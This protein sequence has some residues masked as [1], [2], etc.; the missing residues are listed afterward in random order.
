[1]RTQSVLQMMISG[2]SAKSML[3]IANKKR[4]NKLSGHEVLLCWPLETTTV[5]KADSI[6]VYSLVEETELNQIIINRS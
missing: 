3:K 2:F 5:S 4:Q 6:F 1:M